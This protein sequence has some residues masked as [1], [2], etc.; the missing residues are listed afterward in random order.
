MMNVEDRGVRNW[1]DSTQLDVVI[2]WILVVDGTIWQ[3][4]ENCFVWWYYDGLFYPGIAAKNISRQAEVDSY[5]NCDAIECGNT[6][7]DN[8]ADEV[9]DFKN[10]LLRNQKE[11]E[12]S[13]P[14]IKL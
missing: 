13:T 7:V 6:L 1:S 8:Y 5:A 9:T 11:L 12:N 2:D 10:G 4:S 14:H 3:A